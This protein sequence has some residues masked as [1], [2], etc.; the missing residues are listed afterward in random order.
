ML[1][2]KKT[3]ARALI[4]HSRAFLLDVFCNIEVYAALQCCQVVGAIHL[5]VV[6]FFS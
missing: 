3:S 1:R 4:T 2:S 6:T 5:E